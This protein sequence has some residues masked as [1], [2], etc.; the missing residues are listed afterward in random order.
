MKKITFIIVLLLLG[1]GYLY[2]DTLVQEINTYLSFS[3]CDKPIAYSIGSIDERFNLSTQAFKSDTAEAADIWSTAEGKPLFVYDP[4]SPF[5]ISLIYDQRQTLNTQIN[6]LNTQL[7][8]QKDAIKP[9]LS[10]YNQKVAQ[11]KKDLADLNQQISYWN[12]KGGAPEDVFNKLKQQQAQ[13]QQ[14]QSQ[15]ES[16]A[17]Q[18]NQSTN[19]YNTQVSTL[20][21]DVNSFNQALSVKP[22]EGLYTQNGTD[23]NIKIYFNNSQQELI[24]T[25]A[26]ELGHALGLPHNDNASSVMYP[27]SNISTTLSSQDLLGL[28][29]ACQKIS[30]ITIVE[31]RMKFIFKQYNLGFFK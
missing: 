10:E 26:H 20:N 16:M 23:K 1:A 27:Q 5:T 30:I 14:E 25:L 28:Q 7:N 29:T 21:Q 8:S 4:Q 22:E 24:H 15:L 3:P 17:T 18:L 11:F 19:A 2:R 6:Q 31:E 9:Q 13:L 12:A